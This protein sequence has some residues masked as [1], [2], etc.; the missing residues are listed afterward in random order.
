MVRCDSVVLMVLNL[1]FLK[2]LCFCITDTNA[3]ATKNQ[4]V[5]LN[6]F[7]HGSYATA[8]GIINLPQIM[9]DKIEG[10]TYKKIQKMLR[11]NGNLYRHRFMAPLGL[12]KVP[13]N[14]KYAKSREEESNSVTYPIINAYNNV[15]NSVTKNQEIND[16]Y[17]FGWS[18]LL[19]QT[20][21]RLDAIKLYDAL[22]QITLYYSIKGI[23]SKIRMI[24][25]SHG[26]NV[27]LNMAAIHGTLN[28]YNSSDT[29]EKMLV[30]QMSR[31]MAN[32]PFVY[33]DKNLIIHS[34]CMFAT[35]IQEE[36]ECFCF[37]PMFKKVYNFYSDNDNIQKADFASTENRKSL[38]KIDPQKYRSILNLCNNSI[39][40]I[41]FMVEHAQ[42]KQNNKTFLVPNKV[43]YSKNNN[44][45]LENI[46]RGGKPGHAY[47]L[48]PAHADFWCVYWNKSNL[49][50]DPLP[51]VIFTPAI[52][53]NFE[54][55]TGL[56]D[57][58][59]NIHHTK[60]NIEFNLFSNDDNILQCKTD[61]NMNIVKKSKS[62]LEKWIP[63]NKRSLLSTILSL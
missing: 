52:I 24:T 33:K 6:I 59:L 8:S 51:I 32:L 28:K 45:H 41:K 58:S 17:T 20:E 43:N 47:P 21:R 61:V 53:S 3:M 7:V 5:W 26:G 11:Q 27:V 48:D 12:R 29:R 23:D 18:G 10:T 34:L 54:E 35:P 62:C 49:P 56:Q 14:P 13:L 15:L 46:L 40:Q 31:L 2:V 22:S 36:T 9:F 37:Y 39:F 44:M 25:H 19:S 42:T 38:L 50:F 55:T 63:E 30:S 1:S 60:E 16:F 4:T 57:L